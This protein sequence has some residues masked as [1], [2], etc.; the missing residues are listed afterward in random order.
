MESH[1]SDQIEEHPMRIAIVEDDKVL[2]H[3]ISKALVDGFEERKVKANVTLLQSSNTFIQVASREHFD[4]V[5]LNWSLSDS[6][7]LDL[8][9][10]METYLK[11]PPAVLVVTQ[12]ED[13]SDVVE[14]FNAGADGFVTKPFRPRE[15]AARAFAISRRHLLRTPRIAKENELVFKHLKLN[16]SRE[17]AYVNGEEVPMTH[18]EFRLAHLL[19]SQINC[20]LSRAYLHEYI[21]GHCHN[22]KTRTLDV[23]IHR[24]R[25]KL[26]L[27][28]EYGWN[29]VSVYGHG[30]SLQTLDKPQENQNSGMEAK[31]V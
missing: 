10:W 25:K 2:L 3:R 17:M 22:P 21:W 18:Q 14:A 30:Y 15:L 26:K 19:L 23:H 27:T 20:S 24:V 5:L 11:A 6:I 1:S 29:L 31:A 13:E 28:A 8:I 7:G 9:N 12:R 4:L 16:S